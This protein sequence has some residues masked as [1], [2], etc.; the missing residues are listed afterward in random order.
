M[1]AIPFFFLVLK[2]SLRL[3]VVGLLGLSLLSSATA[4]SFRAHALLG[5]NAAQIDG[6]GL[7][8]YNQGGILGGAKVSLPLSDIISVQGGMLY[9]AK[10]SRNSE[11]EP[12]GIWRL[13]YLEL[14]LEIQARLVNKVYLFGGVSPNYLI[15]ARSDGGGGLA[16]NRAGL[17]DF[18]FCFVAGVLYRFADNVGVL[19]RVSDALHSASRF[20]HFRNRTLG[21]ALVYYFNAE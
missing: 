3:V 5:L 15:R 12:Y 1:F 11:F 10:G 17:R 4:Q 13:S 8:G 19:A 7:W 20:Q 9:S 21:F 16:T 6:D 18:D 14:P 2:V